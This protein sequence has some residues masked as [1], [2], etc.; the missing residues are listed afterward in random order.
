MKTGYI[1]NDI[2]FSEKTEHSLREIGLSSFPQFMFVELHDPN[3][4]ILVLEVHPGTVLIEVKTIVD[5]Q[6]GVEP[7]YQTLIHHGQ[8]LKDYCTIS[9]AGV[10]DGDIL[11]LILGKGLSAEKMTE[12]RSQF[13]SDLRERLINSAEFNEV[14]GTVPHLLAEY[15]IDDLVEMNMTFIASP[16]AQTEV[17]RL[18]DLAMD[19]IERNPRAYRDITAGFL[20]VEAADV[21]SM[22]EDECETDVTVIPEKAAGPS[23]EP[24]PM[25][26]FPDDEE[27]CYSAQPSTWGVCAPGSGESL[28]W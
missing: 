2:K 1:F 3:G 25:M 15:E 26:F 7:R 24:L 17:H 5:E 6:L 11:T 4:I 9:G 8:V 20:E 28:A 10:K 18:T 14:Q 16:E 27:V 13:E 21:D 19:N 23:C 12:L 22:F